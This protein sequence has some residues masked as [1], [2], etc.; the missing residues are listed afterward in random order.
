MDLAA[1]YADGRWV[2][3]LELIDGLDTHRS[4]FREAQVNDPE[5]ARAIALMPDPEE[6]WSPALKDYG[7]TAQMLGQMISLLEVIATQG[8]KPKGFPSPVTE[9]DRQRKRIKVERVLPVAM[10]LGFDEADLI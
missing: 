7:L 4:R 3:L 2:A 10:A 5:T 9:V 8:G 1:W 6:P